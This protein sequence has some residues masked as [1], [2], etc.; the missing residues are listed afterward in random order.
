MALLYRSRAL[1]SLPTTPNLLPWSLLSQQVWS[2]HSSLV[3]TRPLSTR[4][5]SQAT[6]I[7]CLKTTT[8]VCGSLPRP[9]SRQPAR[10]FSVSWP[11][12][13]WIHVKRFS[14]MPPATEASE[15]KLPQSAGNHPRLPQGF[16]PQ[17][18]EQL[19]HHRMAATA[20]HPDPIEASRSECQG[21][22]TLQQAT[23]LAVLCIICISILVLIAWLFGA[24]QVPESQQMPAYE[25]CKDEKCGHQMCGEMRVIEL[26]SKY[27][28]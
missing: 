2:Q 20:K 12:A 23:Y 28:F 3:T 1:A 9:F 25:P 17:V 11:H 5:C 22:R 24:L 15:S 4:Y 13:H 8:N 21:L 26:L 6:S 7:Q 16:R 19:V 14:S 18:T 10:P 27:R